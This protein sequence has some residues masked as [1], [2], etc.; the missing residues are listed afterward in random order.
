M[1]FILKYKGQPVEF[2]LGVHF[3]RQT[4][5]DRFPT[6]A[7]ALSAAASEGLP[8][9]QCQVKRVGDSSPSPRCE[10]A[11]NGERAGVRCIHNPI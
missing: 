5:A 3:V 11:S 6:A 10:S 1:A 8:A 9:N 7:A 4:F 2:D